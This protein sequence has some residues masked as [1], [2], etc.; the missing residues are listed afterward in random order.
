M[1]TEKWVA[2]FIII[3]VLFWIPLTRRVLIWLLPLG[4]G[5]DDLVVFIALSIAGTIYGRRWLSNLRTSDRWQD[6]PQ[7]SR[8]RL[9]FLVIMGLAIA[10][11]SVAIVVY[12]VFSTT[13]WR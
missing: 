3:A 8:T 9:I 5:I 13:Q 6:M 12:S 2:V 11:V 1:N 10:I 4:K 7:S